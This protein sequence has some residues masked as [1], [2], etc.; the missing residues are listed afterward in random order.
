[1]RDRLLQFGAARYTKG[2]RSS[3]P[4][5]CLLAGANFMT[6]ATTHTQAE[7]G[8]LPDGSVAYIFT[9]ANRNHLEARITNYGGRI[10]SLSVPDR[11]GKFADVVLGFDSLPEYL[12]DGTFF[13]ALVGRYANRIGGAHFTLDGIQYKLEKNSD[14]NSLHGGSQGFDKKLWVPRLLTDGGLE[15]TYHSKDGEE[16]FPGNLTATVVYHLTDANEIRIDYHA[17]TDKDTIVNLTNH[18]Y[19]NLKGAGS[20]DILSHVL[21]MHASRFTPVDGGLIPTGE[22]RSVAGTPLDFRTP[23]PIGGRIR[24]NDEQL[25]RGNGYDHNYALDRQGS[26]PRLAARVEEPE[27]GRVLEVYTTEPGI[28]FYTGN[29]LDGTVRGKGGKVYTNRGGFCLETQHFPD[30]PNK[31]G[32]PSVVLHPGQQFAE[33]TIFRFLV[34]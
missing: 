10:V 30:S 13:G 6:G 5:I 22:L 3:W 33:T 23:V 9:L 15:L 11:G 4:A 31:P 20:G 21:T 26:G 2:M 17:A 25:K 8:K 29:F 27:S 12:S 28:Q 14:E 16:G 34:H 1:M 24:Q 18:S 32:F 19:F 7:F